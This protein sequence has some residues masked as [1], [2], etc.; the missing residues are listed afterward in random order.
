MEKLGFVERAIEQIAIILKALLSLG[1]E[2]QNKNDNFEMQLNDFLLH[3]FD[4]KADQI[5]KIDLDKLS[6]LI[7]KKGSN[8]IVLLLSK[9][10]KLYLEQNN[11]PLSYKYFELYKWVE[12]K[13]NRFFHLGDYT[14]E[15]AI[16][17][18]HKELDVVFKNKK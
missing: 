2:E 1:K 10:S 11:P 12:Q 17:T 7:K 8:D 3:F 6:L 18:L 13:Q 9:A 16:N 14:T 4:T 15:N 5:E